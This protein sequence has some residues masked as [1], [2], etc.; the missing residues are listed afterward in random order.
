VPHDDLG[1]VASE[2]ARRSRAMRAMVEAVG[3]PDL[4]WR[5]R[6][7][8]THFAELARAICYQ[9][10]A[11]GAA[12]AI[13]GRFEARYGGAPTPHA[14]LATPA[15]ELR[16][17]GLSAAKVA[18]IRDLASQVEAGTVSLARI[19][20]KPDAAVVA[21]LV[22]VRGIGRWTAE[23]F[24]IF[25]LRRPDVWPVDDLGVRNGYAAMHRLAVAPTARELEALGE[26]FRPYRSV[27]AWYCWRAVDPSF[28]L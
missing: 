10:L 1:A 5:G 16:A 23:M 8:R 25:Q 7:R 19:G 21:E 24:L 20:A 17:V 28:V 26:E 14:V 27:A 15:P 12:R 4:G 13:H 3:P 22:R 11:G 18:A 2:L 6:R 9:Q